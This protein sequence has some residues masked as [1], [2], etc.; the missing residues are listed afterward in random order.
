MAQKTQEAIEKVQ[1][2]GNSLSMSQ[3][4]Q[5]SLEVVATPN[6]NSQKLINIEPKISQNSGTGATNFKRTERASKMFKEGP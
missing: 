5:H 6:N 3:T 4:S 2:D 1:I